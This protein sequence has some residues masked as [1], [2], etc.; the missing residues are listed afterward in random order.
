[1]KCCILDYGSG[2]VKSM[3]N[4]LESMQYDAIISNKI[5]E[6]QRCSHI[7]L[8]GV[9]SFGSAMKNIQNNL[10]LDALYEKVLNENTPILGI[11]VGMQVL[12]SFGEEFGVNVGLGWIPGK[13][14][15]LNN[16][17]LPLP[18]VGWNNV[19]IK[20]ETELL[21]GLPVNSDFYFTHSYK[22]VLDN[23][24]HEVAKTSYE[25]NFTTIVQKDNIFGVQFHPEK[26]QRA[27][28]ILLSNFMGRVT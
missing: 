2:N 21:R 14:V 9:G 13:V 1:M 20:K 15:K 6:I 5:G 26:S 4:M 18:H 8:P 10:P 23:D 22:F 27:G 11:C 7:I 3:L 24:A 25:D 19:E 28:Q 17:N 16:Q 12:A